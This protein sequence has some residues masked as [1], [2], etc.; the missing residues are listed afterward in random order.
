MALTTKSAEAIV[1]K[2]PAKAKGIAMKMKVVHPTVIRGIG[3][4]E[5][6][7][8]HEV[9]EYRDQRELLDAGLAVE[10]PDGEVPKVKKKTYK[11]NPPVADK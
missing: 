9:A 11:A 4:V 2:T 1:A 5:P 6:D 10:V 8:I 3:A 7:E